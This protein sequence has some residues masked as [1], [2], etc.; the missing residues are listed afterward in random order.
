MLELICYLIAVVLL[1]LAALLPVLPYR[2]RIAYAG[3]C[4]YCIPAQRPI[5]NKRKIIGFAKVHTMT[6]WILRNR[7]R[8]SS[9]IIISNYYC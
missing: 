3:L 8:L 4:A 7:K 1:G 5:N 6:A 9:R 2:D